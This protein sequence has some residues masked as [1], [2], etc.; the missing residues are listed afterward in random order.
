M[1]FRSQQNND[2]LEYRNCTAMIERKRRM[3]AR[4]KNWPK[5]IYLYPYSLWQMGDALWVYCCGEPYSLLQKELR[6]RF[7]EKII[8]VAP[9]SYRN[10]AS[11]LPD[12]E[13]YEKGI[14]QEEIAILN[15]GALEFL[16]QEI[17]LKIK[18]LS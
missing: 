11:Y 14:Y 10:Y 2:Q 8:I 18:Q 16:I 1:L 5:E 7:P 6:N 9:Y 3:L 17:I 12:K 13:S 15:R 4:L